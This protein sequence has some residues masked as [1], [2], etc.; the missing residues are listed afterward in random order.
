MLGSP[1]ER[2]EEV[3]LCGGSIKIDRPIQDVDVSDLFPLAALSEKLLKLL[4]RLMRP[5]E[6]CLVRRH[7]NWQW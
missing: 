4:S 6:I 5:H 7:A 3:A 2:T 1:S